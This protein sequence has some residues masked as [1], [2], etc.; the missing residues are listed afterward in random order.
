MNV[1]RLRTWDFAGKFIA[2]KT[3]VDAGHI[4]MKDF[5]SWT[6][7]ELI[8]LGPTFI[9]LGQVAS[10]RQDLF[11]VA[12]TEQL[13]SLLDQVPPMDEQ[14]VYDVLGDRSNLLTNFNFTPYK[15]ASLGQVHMA[16]LLDGTPVVVKVQRKGV[17]ETIENDIQTISEILTFLDFVGVSTSRE[18]F[19]EST[20]YIYDEI[21]YIKECTNAIRF[22]ENFKNVPYVVVPRVYTELSSQSVLVMEF[23]PSVKLM[24]CKQ[25]D[26]KKVCGALVRGFITQVMDHG[27]FHGDPH[28]GNLG[29]TQ[30]GRLVYY[31]FGLAIEMP[32]SLR[33]GLRSMLGLIV[34]KDTRGIVDVLV[35]LGIIIPTTDKEDIAVFFESLLDYLDGR[36]LTQTDLS[37]ALSREKPF[38]L[39]SS[40]IFLARSFSLID[41]LCQQLD[42][43]FKFSTYLE[44]L[45]RNEIAGSMDIQKIAAS[46]MEMPARIKSINTAMT[47]MEKSRVQV[48][49]SLNK[50]SDALTAL[51]IGV[52]I[53]I[54]SFNMVELGHTDI[55]VIGMCGACFLLFRSI[56]R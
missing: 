17:R 33:D 55:G 38:R 16:Y 46:T 14:S 49:L 20:K 30:V 56:W 52:L 18:V 23:V 1:Q 29:I 54:I 36:E 47:S 19:D 22:R 42:P 28:P 41:G 48:K 6:K 26:R 45:V 25:L 51:Q 11:P 35:Q 5:G 4:S 21:D 34:Q 2:R 12:F 10:T 13:E 37:E 53:N 9:K 50:A 8:D 31:D 43:E 44:P 40:F 24:E 7:R 27:F 3:L 32:K 39:P 15:S